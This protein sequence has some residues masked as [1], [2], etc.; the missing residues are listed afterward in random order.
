MDAALFI[1]D[2][3][4]CNMIESLNEAALI[5]DYSVCIN[6]AQSQEVCSN[7]FWDSTICS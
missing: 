1:S 7:A 3:Q 2:G 5:L 4:W 6:K